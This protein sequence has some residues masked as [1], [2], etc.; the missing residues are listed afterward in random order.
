MWGTDAGRA[1]WLV[2]KSVGLLVALVLCGDPDPS[3]S[4]VLSQERSGGPFAGQLRA[5]VLLGLAPGGA[6]G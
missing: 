6:C 3:G 4:G 1:L 5:W 2:L